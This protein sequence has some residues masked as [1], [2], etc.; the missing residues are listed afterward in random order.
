MPA[1][2]Q[3]RQAELVTSKWFLWQRPPFP[4]GPLLRSQLVGG[5]KSAQAPVAIGESRLEGR[6]EAQRLSVS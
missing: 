4:L 6:G 3:V 1:N 5:E 2:V